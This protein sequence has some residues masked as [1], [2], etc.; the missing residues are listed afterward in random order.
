MTAANYSLRLLPSLKSAA[1]KIAKA[2]GTSLNQL[3][4]L[5]LA[6]KVAALTTATYFQERSQK[7]DTAAFQRVL[8]EAPDVEPEPWDRL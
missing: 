8:T 5:A 2:E 4:N 3:I 1:E 7:S 6:E